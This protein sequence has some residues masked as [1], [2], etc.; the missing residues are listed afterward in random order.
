MYK[1]AMIACS[2]LEGPLLASHSVNDAND[3]AIN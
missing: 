1:Y 2:P 3:S